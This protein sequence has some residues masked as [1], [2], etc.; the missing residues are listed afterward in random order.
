MI[1][2]ELRDRVFTYHIL[3]SV[4]GV[5]FFFLG[6]F[7]YCI[8]YLLFIYKDISFALTYLFSYG[9]LIN[10][11]FGFLNFSENILNNILDIIIIIF[12]IMTIWRMSTYRK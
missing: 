1:G 5:L 12:C 9:G 2:K 10:F 4:L 6:Y 3:Y 11:V 8:S 7:T